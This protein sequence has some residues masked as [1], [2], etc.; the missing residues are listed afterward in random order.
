MA[1]ARDPDRCPPGGLLLRFT[2][3]G[4]PRPQGS[5]RALPVGKPCPVCKRSRT[6]LVEHAD[7]KLKRWRKDVTTAAREAWGGRAPL[8]QPLILGA[9]FLF[10]RPPSHLKKSGGLR[11]GKPQT[12]QDAPDL[13]KLV[14]AVEDALTDAKVWTDDQR[15][16]GYSTIAKDYTRDAHAIGVEV[17]VQSWDP[18]WEVG[19]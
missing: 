14:R 3:N 4:N 7:A 9:R 11:K 5:K 2:V 19:R 1:V 15:V 8:D 16:V 18:L 10:P 13:S 6:V 17:V 12:K